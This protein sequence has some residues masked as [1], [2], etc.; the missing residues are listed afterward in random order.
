MPLLRLCISDKLDSLDFWKT[1]YSEF[2]LP[3][4][5]QR[6]RALSLFSPLSFLE[7]KN[8]T[9]LLVTSACLSLCHLPLSLAQ[10]RPA[11]WLSFWVT[12]F[13]FIV[14]LS[15][16]L[17]YLYYTARSNTCSHCICD[18]ISVPNQEGGQRM[19]WL[20][21]L[22]TA[23]WLS[24]LSGFHW[25]HSTMLFGCPHC[26]GYIGFTPLLFGMVLYHQRW[27]SI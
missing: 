22:S 1:Q 27:V 3:E 25:F 12:V 17:S 11:R 15:G 26:L 20:L 21:S 8:H 23:F 14:H 4:L 13:L 10:L 24:T 16:L 6:L 7:R 18:C 9:L 19:P 2:G 5:P